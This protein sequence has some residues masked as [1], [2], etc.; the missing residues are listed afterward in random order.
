MKFNG[1]IPKNNDRQIIK[2]FALFP[3][4]IY[5]TCDPWLERRHYERRWLEIVYIE[6]SYEVHTGCWESYKF[7]D[8]E[9]YIKFRTENK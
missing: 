4:T 9:D 7:V 8:K 6:Q 5:D 1:Y 3:V 2:R